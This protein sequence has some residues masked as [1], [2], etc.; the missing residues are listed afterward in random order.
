MNAESGAAFV[1]ENEKERVTTY[2]KGA[3]R[4]NP[5]D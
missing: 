5:G 2:T 1:D 4:T 3:N